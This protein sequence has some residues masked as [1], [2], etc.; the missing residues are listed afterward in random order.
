MVGDDP[1]TS[2]PSI[3]GHFSKSARANT[4]PLIPTLDSGSLTQSIM[5]RGEV[6]KWNYFLNGLQPFLR[7]YLQPDSWD[8]LPLQI[9]CWARLLSV[10][11]KN[12][13]L[14]EWTLNV[15]GFSSEGLFRWFVGTW[16]VKLSIILGDLESNGPCLM[17]EHSMLGFKTRKFPD[18]NVHPC[19][20]SLFPANWVIC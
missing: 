17:P 13:L 14:P 7:C 18:S 15:R 11:V 2:Q 4:S 20:E 1:E 3:A 10:I 8:W 19:Q 6:R 16:N 12:F 9:D 5:N